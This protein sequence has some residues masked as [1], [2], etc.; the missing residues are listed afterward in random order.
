MNKRDELYDIPTCCTKFLKY[1][2]SWHLI[3]SIC[4][5][6]LKNNPVEVKFPWIIT[7]QPP[8]IVIPNWCG[9]NVLQKL[10]GI[11]GIKHHLWIDSMFPPL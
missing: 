3:E 1:D 8:L 9:E 10:H 6:Q 11:K 7:S 5:I 4:H 2:P